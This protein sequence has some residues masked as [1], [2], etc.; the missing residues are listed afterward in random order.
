MLVN[1]IHFADFFQIRQ[2]KNHYSII[3]TKSVNYSILAVNYRQCYIYQ[4]KYIL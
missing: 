3:F 2:L 1:A 4:L